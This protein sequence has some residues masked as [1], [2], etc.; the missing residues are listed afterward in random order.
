ME[1]VSNRPKN[2]AFRQ[3]RLRAFKPVHTAKSSA[4]I[5]LV[6][7]LF[8]IGIGIV[9]Y[10]ECNNQLEYSIRY[11]DQCQVSTICTV[12]LK[13]NENMPSPVFLYYQLTNFYQ[14]YRLY[15]KSKSYT[16]LRG[17][18]AP[19]SELSNCGDA[20]YNKDFIGYY[21]GKTLDPDLTARPCGLIA[22]SDFNDS[23]S[24][25]NYNISFDHI[26]SSIDTD[27]FVD[28]DPSTQWRTVDSHFINWMKV[29]PLPTFRKLWGIIN[30]DL[31]SGVVL[32]NVT[33][34][35]DVS[36]WDGEKA[37]VLATNGMFGGNNILLGIVFL[38]AG[39]FCF[40]C[41]I[42]FVVTLLFCKPKWLEQDPKT[43]KF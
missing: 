24:I 28:K 4:I 27:M 31:K 32:I 18:A 39:G 19:S 40:L 12:S 1:E 14:N 10:V 17:G 36:R 21:S 25:T 42:V 16:Q 33:N 23:I 38:G 3:Q 34:N 7:S 15:V 6:A 30:Q 41:S 29:A 5:F 9:L 8:F 11:D 22:R 43:W 37:V 2:T 13:I 35:Y 20:R 26:V